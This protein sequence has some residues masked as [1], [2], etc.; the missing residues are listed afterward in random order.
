MA[1]TDKQVDHP[2]FMAFTDTANAAL[3][4]ALR[5]HG[6]DPA[7][8]MGMDTN[9]NRVVDAF[10]ALMLRADKQRATA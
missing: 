5:K 3:D 7:V 2:K 4:A 10:V 9:A 8:L 6:I 1:L